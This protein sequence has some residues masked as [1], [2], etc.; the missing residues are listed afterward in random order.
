MTDGKT[1]RR[2]DGRQT[3]TKAVRAGAW[4]WAAPAVASA[5]AAA[6]R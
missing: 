3:A 5:S 6:L 1:E 4:A 2:K